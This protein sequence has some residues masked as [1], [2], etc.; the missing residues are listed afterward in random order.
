VSGIGGLLTIKLM[1]GGNPVNTYLTF[2][3]AYAAAANGDIIQL[4]AVEITGYLRFTDTI[5]VSLKGGYDS[6]FVLNPRMTTIK[7]SMTILGEGAVT[8]ENV[9]IK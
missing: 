2:Y 4:Q 7:G 8:V 6:A 9:I 3:N 1:R 5:N